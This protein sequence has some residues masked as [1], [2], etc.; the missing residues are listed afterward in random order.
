MPDGSIV[1]NYHQIRYPKDAVC[2]VI[3]NEKDEILFILNKR[4]TLSKLE[5]EIPAG[6]VEDGER[7]ED[8]A[9]R[10]AKEETGC[11][12]KD[13]KYLFTFDPA[14]GMLLAKVHCFAARVEAEETA[15]DDNEVAG[16]KWFSIDEALKLFE[17]NETECGVTMLS[18]LYA[19]KFYLRET[20]I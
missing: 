8:A 11:D 17:N 10:E 6:K 5:W 3:F 4:Y 15:L 20:G 14:N 18:V 13:L 19:L 9:L 12:L 16:K 1:E 7:N 2:I